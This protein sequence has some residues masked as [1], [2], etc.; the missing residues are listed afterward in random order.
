M[1]TDKLVLEEMTSKDY[2]LDSNAHF[3]VHEVS[4]VHVFHLK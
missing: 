1:D 2:Y 4:C 3:A